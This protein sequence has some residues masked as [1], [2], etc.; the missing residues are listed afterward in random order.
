MN[1]LITEFVDYE[2]DWSLCASIREFF[3]VSLTRN[4]SWQI[5]ADHICVI[6][7]KVQ[8][9]RIPYLLLVLV[10]ALT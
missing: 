1:V 9:Q 3:A 8:E 10:Y 6:F 5:A 7:S 4:T 2:N